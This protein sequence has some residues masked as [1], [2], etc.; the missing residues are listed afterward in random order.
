MLKNLLLGIIAAE[1][2]VARDVMKQEPGR[3]DVLQTVRVLVTKSADANFFGSIAPQDF[4]LRMAIA[5]AKLEKVGLPSKALSDL[6]I[7]LI[8]RF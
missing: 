2:T 1:F 7:C 3:I 6:D 4:R 8:L 5:R